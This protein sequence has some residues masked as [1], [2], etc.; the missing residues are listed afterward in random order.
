MF[1]KFINHLSRRNTLAFLDGLLHFHIYRLLYRPVQWL[2]DKE[3]TRDHIWTIVG[4]VMYTNYY[5][6]YTLSL[7]FSLSLSIS[8]CSIDCHYT[9]AHTRS[10]Y[11]T[12]CYVIGSKPGWPIGALLG[13]HVISFPPMGETH[14]L[15]KAPSCQSTCA[16]VNSP[17][18][19]GKEC[20]ILT[21]TKENK[22]E[23]NHDMLY[24]Q[25][26]IL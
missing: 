8:L 5:N 18:M 22:G 9:H 1:P 12:V 2:A 23:R 13:A 24:W 20:E 6:K 26:P 14:A 15:R 10:T 7:S 11:N 21:L 19:P 4:V 17:F 3:I 25:K 16:A